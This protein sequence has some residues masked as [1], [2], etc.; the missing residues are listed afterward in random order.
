MFH[1]R[2]AAKIESTRWAIL[3]DS[4]RAIT[5][6]IDRGLDEGDR[7]FFHK[8]AEEDLEA[9]VADLGPRIP[10]TDHAF[11]SGSTG[12]LFVDGPVIPQASQVAKGRPDQKNNAGVRFAGRGR[13]GD[14]GFFDS[15]KSKL[16]TDGRICVRDVRE[17]GIL[18][19][20]GV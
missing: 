10:D 18:D 1:P 15:H 4:L 7:E 2:I 19:R 17:R 6:A 20:V 9:F 14:L 5:R 16:K 13:H 8:L 12:V 3:P 11:R